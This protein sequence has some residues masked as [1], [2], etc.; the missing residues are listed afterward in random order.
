MSYLDQLKKQAQVVKNQQQ[1]AK[2]QQ[3][4]KE[5]R[6]EQQVKPALDKIQ[7]YLVDLAE[8]LNIVKPDV[9]TRFKLSGFGEIDNLLQTHYELILRTDMDALRQKNYAKKQPET[10][11]IKLQS[12]FSFH[13]NCKADYPIRICKKNLREIP[14][15]REYLHKHGFRFKFEEE[16]TPDGK[17]KRGLFLL[18]PTVTT[19]L[20][21]QGNIESC[22]IEMTTINFNLLGKQHYTI[23][24]SDVNERFLDELAKYIV[25]DSHQLAIHEKNTDL[26]KPRK[27]AV[28]KKPVKKVEMSDLTVK[29]PETSENDHDEF[30]EWLRQTKQNLEQQAVEK[31][32]KKSSL[33]SLL[34]IGG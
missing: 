13:F 34:K 7:T 1:T 20:V 2:D 32:A 33:F 26:I 18:R 11:S 21:F 22:C 24:P 6:F 10:T 28:S 5:T 14:L 29:S 27:T 31:P 30:N 16:K 12:A 25:R 4:Q 17:F 3:T 19:K 23:K 8:Q 15:Q 9:R